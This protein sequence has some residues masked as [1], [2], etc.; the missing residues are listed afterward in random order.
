MMKSISTSLTALSTNSDT[1]FS[2]DDP[3][4][5][6]PDA[7]ALDGDC[8]LGDLLHDVE[9]SLLAGTLGDDLLPTP[10]D[11]HTSIERLKPDLPAQDPPDVYDELPDLDTFA[12]LLDDLLDLDLL[13]ECPDDLLDL[14]LDDL[15]DLDLPDELPDDLLALTL[16][17]E[18]PLSDFL[19]SAPD[20]DLL[21]DLAAADLLE[22]KPLDP[23]L[24]DFSACLDEEAA[25]DPTP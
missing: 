11:T 2:E 4:H 16:L 12:E 10:P 25:L 1:A 19:I 17:S 3:T 5:R 23:L 8:L 14:E 18:L 9:V 21:D 20:N 22:D 7:E 13:N 24:D 6:L 15:L